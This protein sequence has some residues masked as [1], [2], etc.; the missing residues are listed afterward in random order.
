MVPDH[1]LLRRIGKGAYGEVWLAKNAMGRPRAV[2]IVHSLL[3]D[4]PS[5]NFERELKGLRRF[6]PLSR[7]HDS[8]V[9]LLHVGF[10]PDRKFLYCVMELADDLRT[11]TDQALSAY[12]PKTLASVINQ[13]GH[14]SANE[15]VELGITLAS[16]LQFLHEQNFVHRDIKPANVIYVDGRPKIADIGLVAEIGGVQSTVGT[17][18]YVP[19]EGPGHAQGDV[20][21]LGKVLY[22]AATGKDRFD[23]PE[24]PDDIESRPDRDLFLEL[25]VVL[26]KCCEN[27]QTHRY[28]TASAVQDDLQL[29]VAGR[30]LTRLRRLERITRVGLIAG[31]TILLTL[32]AVGL[33]S[34]RVR[35]ESEEKAR[36]LASSLAASG[37]RAV[38][39][40]DLIA[41]LPWY[42][43]ALEVSRGNKPIE[44]THR[45]QIELV[46]R[47]TPRLVALDA[48]PEAIN[49]VIF[50]PSGTRLIVAG[51]RS[52]F[53]AIDLD[54]TNPDRTRSS[55]F[56]QEAPEF[57]KCGIESIRLLNGGPWLLAASTDKSVHLL[58]SVTGVESNAI[59][60]VLPDKVWAL[61]VHQD[62]DLFATS[63][64]D[65]IVRIWKLSTRTLIATSDTFPTIIRC[66]A[67]HP[68]GKFLL[69][70]GFD[71]SIK[72]LNPLNAQVVREASKQP[73]WVYEVRFDSRGS[74]F[75][76]SCQDGRARL[77]D[78][79][80]LQRIREFKHPSAVR[81]TAFNPDGRLIATACWDY[82]VRAWDTETGDEVIPPLPH[83]SNPMRIQFSPDGR[84][85]ATATTAGIL[86]TWDLAPMNQWASEPERSADLITTP[87][88]RINDRGDRLAV[89]QPGAVEIFSPTNLSH[90]LT[91]LREPGLKDILLA[92][93]GTRAIAIVSED[94]THPESS[95]VQG[96]IVHL[97]STQLGKVVFS[98]PKWEPNRVLLSPDGCCLA[99]AERVEGHEEI[100][101]IHLERDTNFFS[102]Q[103][104]GT[105]EPCMRFSTGGKWFALADEN[106]VTVVPMFEG[107]DRLAIH[108]PI[109][110]AALA[111]NASQT[112]L[113]TACQDVTLSARSAY[114]WNLPGG[115][116]IG[117]PLGH[118]DGVTS[119]DFSPVNSAVITGGEDRIAQVWQLGEK[120]PPLRLPHRGTV[121]FCTFNRDGEFVFT[122]DD[123]RSVRLW[124]A[125]SG[126]PVT[127]PL[128]DYFNAW[129]GKL[130]E[131][132]QLL[133]TAG[134]SRSKTRLW[135]LSPTKT[136]TLSTEDLLKLSSLLSCKMAD[137]NGV[138]IPMD[139][140]KLADLWNDLR[141]RHPK[142]FSVSAKEIEE[143]SAREA[144]L[145]EQYRNSPR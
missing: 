88:Y 115:Q 119:A 50:D 103:T 25:N 62:A 104:T 49:D 121:L 85:L 96:R 127:P 57:E 69:A 73:D 97:D 132:G 35:R 118:F 102:T 23:Y 78:F 51:D 40:G 94:R 120:A 48:F 89:V 92:N 63:S 15:T 32:L 3:T 47:H 42:T 125:H 81:S 76:S 6:E 145:N 111:F 16:G 134:R 14:L 46:L 34:F 60:L 83:E 41:S 141:A 61:D 27:K 22:E 58:N 136:A 17:Q 79:Q 45:K 110:V 21:G 114:I 43:A 12:Q 38:D 129:Q 44:E 126:E 2:K 135:D 109:H 143:W 101:L 20:F 8:F 24:L 4:V 107:G 91:S 124:D 90:P 133:W 99:L 82:T 98:F 56:H 54:A 140:G 142:I 128:H 80:T 13:S 71:G 95:R 139:S 31:S 53:G 59:R 122:G 116:Q 86:R 123:R 36:Q 113:L 137:R 138:E 39:A 131:G 144:S 37:S 106:N 77:F 66:V 7:K 84:L 28:D 52:A 108:P 11:G 75:V 10:S 30:S 9:D 130:L 112:A 19:P 117:G 64:R 26:L 29:L 100:R 18:G 1:E 74:R 67:F 5:D 105:S 70:A 33:F 68:S 65:Q 87:L 93:E 72:V 55:H